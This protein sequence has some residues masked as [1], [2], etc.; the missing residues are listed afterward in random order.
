MHVMRRIGCRRRGALGRVCWHRSGYFIRS[1]PD[2]E[3][4][5]LSEIYGNTG[6]D[7]LSNGYQQWRLPSC[8]RDPPACRDCWVRVFVGVWSAKAHRSV[9]AC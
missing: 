2:E 6:M 8:R 5:L 9:V 4:A 7:E 1:R 3:N